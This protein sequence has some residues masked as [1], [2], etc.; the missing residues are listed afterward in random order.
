MKKTQETIGGVFVITGII[1]LIAMLVFG[2][3]FYLA[4]MDSWLIMLLMGLVFGGGFILL[5]VGIVYIPWG[6]FFRWIA[7]I[8]RGRKGFARILFP[9]GFVLIG[10]SA[11]FI[12]TA[13]AGWQPPPRANA[14]L[15][16]IWATFIGWGYGAWMFL[17][18]GG[19]I[20]GV[21][22]LIG[23]FLLYRKADGVSTF[24]RVLSKIALVVAIIAAV[25]V[26]V[27]AIVF[28]VLMII[29]VVVCFVLIMG[30]GVPGGYQGGYQAGTTTKNLGSGYIDRSGGVDYLVINGQRT[31]LKD[32]NAHT[33]EATDYS[34]NK[35]Y[36]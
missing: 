33:G 32:Y 23:C 19:A 3:L 16:F 17:A 18:I 2:G 9:L 15:A 5:G 20:A 11:Y 25:A 6:R 24:E 4:G 35:Y 21:W 34:G 26:A 1:M 28:A 22:C 29:G 7:R 10:V 8:V 14:V 27:A 30:G 36:L 31:Q 12:V 13:I